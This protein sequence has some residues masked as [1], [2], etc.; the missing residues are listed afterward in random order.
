MTEYCGAYRDLPSETRDGH[1]SFSSA[2]RLY[3]G[4][5]LGY[6]LHQGFQCLEEK[7]MAARVRLKLLYRV[8][9]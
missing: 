6:A 7:K 9:I 8:V 3:R 5:V 2:F 1:H 4:P